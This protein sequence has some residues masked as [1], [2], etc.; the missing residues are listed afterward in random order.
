MD[1]VNAVLQ[2]RSVFDLTHEVK[3]SCYMGKLIPFL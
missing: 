1:D 3:L 2:K